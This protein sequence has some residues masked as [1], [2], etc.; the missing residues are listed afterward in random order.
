MQMQLVVNERHIRTSA[1]RK[2]L[3]EGDILLIKYRVDLGVPLNSA[4]KILHPHMSNVATIKLVKWHTEMETALSI[5]DFILYDCIYKSLFPWW[6]NE[7]HEQPDEACYIGQ[8]P[9]GYWE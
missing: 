7:D 2:L 4:V 3:K 6:V 1:K 5:E 8:F 9:Y